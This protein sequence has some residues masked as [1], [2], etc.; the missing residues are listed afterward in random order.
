MQIR[1]SLLTKIFDPPAVA[2]CENLEAPRD[3]ERVPRN[4]ES[5]NWILGRHGP[6]R[7]LYYRARFDDRY[8]PLPLAL[9]ERSSIDISRGWV[10]FVR[11]LL[12]LP[13]T[14]ARPVL[15]F[16]VVGVLSGAASLFLVEAMGHIRGNEKF[17]AQVEFTTIA[18][19]CLGKRSHLILQ[20]ILFLALQSVNISS[21]I[22]SAQV[23]YSLVRC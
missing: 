8:H 13:L 16:V 19:L 15:A 5:R 20:I 21:I 3:C 14:S 4:A 18:E 23:T 12:L 9:T 7:E 11:S 10:A 2:P 1:L 6:P 22:I 17:Q